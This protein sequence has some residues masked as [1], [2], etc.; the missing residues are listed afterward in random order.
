MIVRNAKSL[1][2]LI[3]DRRLKRG[4]SQAQ[5]GVQIGAS[6]FWVAD[7]EK[8][9]PT[10]EVGLVLGALQVLGL[11]LDVHSADTVREHAPAGPTVQVR[12]HETG[13]ARTA[14]S[15]GGKPLRVSRGARGGTA[16]HEP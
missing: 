12:F 11:V 13:H 14:L 6:R 7:V 5:L 3:R 2:Q 8:G 4:W 16:Q 15:S 9:K 1:G 10:V